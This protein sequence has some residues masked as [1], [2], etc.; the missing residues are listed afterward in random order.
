MRLRKISLKAFRGVSSDLELDCDNACRNLLVYGENGSAKSSFARALEHLFA[1]SPLPEH[2][3][4]NHKNLFTTTMP[5]ILA[6][7]S[8][9]VAGTVTQI[10]LHWTHA[11]GK[12]TAPWLL[13]SAAR[14]A[15]LDHRKL[16]T[17]SERSRDVNLPARFFATAVEYLFADLPAGSSGTTV[18]GL[19]RKMQADAQGYREAKMADGREADSGVADAV[20]HYKPIEDAANNLNAVLD[21]YL[22]P[23]GA[24]RPPLVLETERILQ[25]FEGHGLTVSLSFDHITFNRN[26]GTFAGGELHPEITYCTKPLGVKMG[27]TWV[28]THHEVLNEARLTALALAM[29][30][31]AVRLQDQI[32]YIAGAGDPDEP[33]RLLVLDDILIGLD[34][35]HRIPVLEI[36]QHEF[37][38]DR[39]YQVVLLTHDRV[40]F[41]VCRLQVEGKD[42]KPIELYARRGKGP[43]GS[44]FP[45]RKD[46]A[47]NLLERARFFLDDCHELPAAANYTRSALE[48]ALRSICEKRHVP[49]PFHRNPEK[50][51]AETFIS[52]LRNEKLHKGGKWYLIPLSAQSQLRALRSTV[53]NALSHFN[54]TTITEPEIRKAIALAEKLTR[55]ASRIKALDAE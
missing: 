44:D 48:T 23:K 36:I 14:S 25:R 45:E 53:L 7:F 19:Y 41:D 32:P 5:E 20:A 55:I 35:A 9:T 51:M 38:K 8:G 4:L 6:Q 40:W 22:L 10:P 34:Y 15:F 2:D 1:P 13:S 43:D 42:W 16:M 33:A 47:A 3:I 27:E 30:F 29:F 50:L 17:L 31:A 49:I 28:T 39:R 18:S 21:D 12:P 11:A 26:E 54:P 37:A 24:D 52:A 46:S